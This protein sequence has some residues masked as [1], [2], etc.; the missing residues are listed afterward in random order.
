[1]EYKVPPICLIVF[2]ET[3]SYL[4]GRHMLL[5]RRMCRRSSKRHIARPFLQSKS[6]PYP[7]VMQLYIVLFHNTDRLMDRCIRVPMTVELKQYLGPPKIGYLYHVFHIITASVWTVEHI[8]YASLW[9]H[10]NPRTWS[11]LP[12]LS[13]SDVTLRTMFEALYSLPD[14]FLPSSL[15]L[16]TRLLHSLPITWIVEVGGTRD[17]NVLL[18]YLST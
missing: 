7:S 16:I 1:M 11:V 5:W 9:Y 2:L 17:A 13:K 4:S 15:R 10:C 12:N 8:W 18:S 14:P 3:N 6:R